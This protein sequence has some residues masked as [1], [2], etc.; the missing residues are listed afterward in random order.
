MEYREGIIVFNDW[1]ITQKL[2]EG[3][4][5][6]VFEIEKMDFGISIKS[7]LK[8][9]HIPGV[10][11]D[12]KA[13][14]R[15]GMTEKD[16]EEY[17]YGFV[18]EILKEI[19]IM[20][21]LKGH[22]NIVTYEDHC[23]IPH[24][25]E[26]GWDILIKME[27]LTPLGD[28]LETHSMNEE[29][30]ARLGYEISNALAYTARRGMIHRDVKPG[31]IFIDRFGKYKLGDF[32]IARTVEKTTSELSSKGTWSYMA[33]EVYLRKKYNKQVDIYSLGIVMYRFLNDNRLPF[34]PPI[35]EK[36]TYR[37][38]EEAFEK[39]MQGIPVPEPVNGSTKLKRIVL[40]ACEYHPQDRYSSIDKMHM[41]LEQL[42]TELDE[43][44]TVMPPIPTP[45]GGRKKLFVLI[46]TAT[47]VVLIGG[48]IFSTYVKDRALEMQLNQMKAENKKDMRTE[49]VAESEVQ[50]ETLREKTTEVQTEISTEV[51]PET[52]TELETE[53]ETQ[54]ELETETEPE[55]QTE[56][57]TEIET[58]TNE[59][60]EI[61]NYD[62][63]LFY[64][65]CNALLDIK[66]G[67]EVKFGACEQDNNPSNGKEEIEW[68]VLDKKDNQI[69]IISKK[70]LDAQEYWDSFEDTDWGKSEVRKWLN[71]SFMQN[72]FSQYHQSL[73]MDTSV[74]ADK[75]PYYQTNTG[76]ASTDKIYLLSMEE[77]QKYFP[78]TESRICQPTVYAKVKGVFMKNLNT[79]WWLRTVGKDKKHM[80]AIYTDGEI[81]NEGYRVYVKDG[82]VRPVIWL[83]LSS[84][85]QVEVPQEYFH[86][87]KACRGIVA[88]NPS[89][90]GVS[91]DRTFMEAVAPRQEEEECTFNEGVTGETTGVKE[92]QVDLEVAKQLQKI[93]LERGYQVV[94]LREDNE[95]CLSA[96]NR[97]IAAAEAGVDIQVVISCRKRQDLGESGAMAY[98]P[99]KDNPS[100]GYMYE[101]CEKLSQCVLS[102]YCATGIFENNGIHETDNVKDINWSSMPVT[103]ILLG[104]IKDSS[105]EEKLADQNNWVLMAEGIAK[106]IDIYFEGE[107]T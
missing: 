10:G 91:D 6:T 68:E 106:G 80:T 60:I 25:H 83:D 97:A 16:T 73:I 24:E 52:Q 57:E 89:C 48:V 94:M 72:A 74:T 64:E 90:V 58:E 82:G 107:E 28:W 93:L 32:G 84:I 15:E 22:P 41:D 104:C 5:G 55:T 75:N 13:V 98:I 49:A 100:V 103:N 54:T 9:V 11:S 51:E 33:P 59:S 69:L 8:V 101:E 2:G 46:G 81:R 37:D 30:V 18:E 36:I 26:I 66:V 39:R 19:K 70:V 35:T 95:S 53:M 92:S 14:M 99:K 87:Q 3:A 65:Q 31:N 78:D 77:V 23:V 7:A 42:M 76:A 105:D 4:T 85:S 1:V 38:K 45:S 102:E 44:T 27:L 71:E 17:F 21:S 29:E 61:S 62:Q 86:T 47:A 34:C 40:K 50:K 43:D 12:V 56:L 67:D 88:I 63:A 96:S 79:W 20:V